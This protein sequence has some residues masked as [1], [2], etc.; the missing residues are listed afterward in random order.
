M[1]LGTGGGERDVR[2][3]DEGS[4]GE[5]LPP[6]RRDDVDDAAQR[7]AETPAS[8]EGSAGVQ[9]LSCRR[10]GV[11]D[12]AQRSEETPALD[13]GIAGAQPSPRR[14]D[15]VDDAARHPAEAP[16]PDSYRWSL[17]QR[18]AYRAYLLPAVME[19]RPTDLAAHAPLVTR[20]ADEGDEVARQILDEA[21]AALVETVMAL[22]PEPGEPLVVTGGLLAPD[23]PL[24]APLIEH[25]APLGLTVSPVVDG[26][27]GAVALARIAAAR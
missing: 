18:A 2:T 14:R 23:G 27:A 1:G 20:A 22:A 15:G 19:R 9:P 21:A 26:S 11:D 12:A 17:A 6:R 24:L 25:L 5:Q 16:A 3:S 8:D 13:E 7:A 4:A 10:D